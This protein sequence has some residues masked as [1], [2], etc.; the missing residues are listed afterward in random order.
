MQESSAWGELVRSFAP[1]VH[2]VARGYGLAEAEAE[3]VFQEVFL[4]T[5]LLGEPEDD[6]AMRARI[7]ELTRGVAAARSDLR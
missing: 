5:W 2:A 4:R 7:V 3:E 1:Y 6:K